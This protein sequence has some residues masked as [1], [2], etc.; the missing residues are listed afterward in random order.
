MDVLEPVKGGRA[1]LLRQTE[2]ILAISMERTMDLDDA[3]QELRVALAR[4]AG[5]ES[6]GQLEKALNDASERV[7][8]NFEDLVKERGRTPG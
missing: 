7:R 5:V 3:P 1:H 2:I 6:F 4:A 8:A